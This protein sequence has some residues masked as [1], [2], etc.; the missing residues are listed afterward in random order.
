MNN[1]PLRG[2]I[3]NSN[4]THGPHN[5][6][7]AQ[8]IS[9]AQALRTLYDAPAEGFVE[10]RKALAAQAKRD[11]DREL[12]RQIG[13]LR[14]PTAA[15]MLANHLDDD[16]LARLFAVGTALRAAQTRLDTDE[17]KRLTRERQG[18]IAGL[19][20]G[21]NASA[22]VLDEVRATLLAATADSAAE[23]A[24]ASRVLVRALSYAGWGEVD[25]AD[26]LAHRAAA[27]EGRAALRLVREPDEARGASDP[28]GPGRADGGS[29]SP[30][31]PSTSDDPGSLPPPTSTAASPSPDSAADAAAAD[32][33]EREETARRARQAA[34]QEKIRQQA[35]EKAAREVSKAQ[36]RM[37]AAQDAY[38]AASAAR[39]AARAALDLAEAELRRLTTP[40][41][42]TSGSS[43]P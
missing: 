5:G 33:A 28:T 24:V 12:A 11:G 36:R 42:G 13:A 37:S 25:L 43:T 6:R 23:Q 38:D 39:A 1:F 21:L 19:V 27:R 34:A 22:A 3:E 29:P 7:M 41:E 31:R 8:Q 4:L 32:E 15:A 14:K 18:V 17:M 40:A 10:R 16:A 26:A 35:Q 30:R 9:L 20:A 2:E